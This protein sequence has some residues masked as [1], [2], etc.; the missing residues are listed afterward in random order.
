MVTGLL[1]AFTA[2]VLNSI[3]GLLESDATRRVPRGRSLVTQ[4]RYLGGLLVDGLGWA[5]TVAALRFLP[6]F[7][8]QAVL[9]GA[10]ALTAVGAQALYRS[11]LRPV[12]TLACAACVAGLVLVAAS[13]GP[14]RPAGPSWPAMLA[15]VAVAIVLVV[16]LVATWSARAAWPLALIAGLGFGGNSVAVRAVH[17]SLGDDPLAL[18][19]APPVY[20]VIVFWVL[21]LLGYTRALQRGSLA[22]VT[23]I[24]LV[25]EVTVPGV[26]G[27]VLLGDSVRPGWWAA[28]AAGLVLAVAGVA[29]LAGSPAHLPPD[30]L[31]RRPGA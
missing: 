6:V 5:S 16:G 21:G 18:L 20:L 17:L 30:E 7:V 9:G 14:D 27:I 22:R 3:A 11:T 28:L 29:V 1:F 8:V 31:D 4:P 26:G 25:T 19:A 12:D 23:A 10:I 15:L 24:L 2:T 13:G